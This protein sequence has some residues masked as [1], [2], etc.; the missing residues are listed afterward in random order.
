MIMMMQ[1]HAKR[2]RA[3][4]ALLLLA[5]AFAPARA[6]Q[7]PQTLTFE[8]YEPKSTLVVPERKVD[9]ARFPMI[10][11]HSHHSNLSPEYVDKLVKEMDAINLRVIVN[12]SGG[13]GERLTKVIAAMKGRHP[14]RFV[15]FANLSFEDLNEPGYGKRAAARLAQDVKNGA[16]GLK[17]FKNFGMDLK[18]RN[19]E[20]VK[21]DDPEFDPVWQ[22]CATLKI[23]VLIHVA[24]PSAFFDPIDKNNERWLELKQFPNRARPPARYPAFETLMTERNHMLEKNP[25]TIFILAHMGY[26][27]NDLGRL[28]RLFDAYPNAYVDVAAILA[29]LGRQPIRAVLDPYNPTGST[30]HVNFTTSKTNRWDTVGPP[31]KCHLNW[32]VLDSDWEAEFCRVAEA[33]PRVLA[34]VKNHS[35]GLE[36][37]YRYGPETRHYR[38]DFVVLVD[39]GRGADDPLHL[40]VEIKGYRGEDAKE[41]KS[42]METYWVPGV[43][44]LGSHGR[45]AFAEFAD[46]WQIQA[47]FADEVEAAFNTLIE[48]QLR[49]RD[50][51]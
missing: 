12:L 20:R 45:W 30:A 43:N 38:P 14:D 11:I 10:D 33:H 2:L 32:V 22:M 35:L 40:V 50:A 42:T 23:P 21:V 29:E 16:Q 34:Y 51:P 48:Q 7:A 49:Q 6:Q 28:G 13:T 47:D 36:V 37:P 24:E 26:H 5:A 17:I 4:A 15:V 1:T 8:E 19:G 9:R 25:K 27:G 39:D 46:V 44:Q 3:A 31:P 18:Y 41:K